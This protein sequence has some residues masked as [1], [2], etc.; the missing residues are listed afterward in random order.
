MVRITYIPGDGIGP[1]IIDSARR[2]IDASGADIVWVEAAAGE[3][4]MHTHG[5]PLPD[6]TLASISETRVALKGPCTTPVG[7]GFRSVNVALRQELDLYANLRP[8]KSYKGVR[9]RYHDVDLVVVREN[10]E[11]L[12]ASIEFQEGKPATKD[13]IAEIKKLD[14][15]EMPTDSGISIKSISIGG[16]RRIVEFAFEYARANGRKKVTA[17]HKANIMKFTDG[18]FLAVATE[19][20]GRYPD[21]AFE[22]RIVDNMC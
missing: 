1:S 14:G 4:A 9:S 13:L 17:V 19:V 22:D 7:K 5:S 16:S 12:Y 11:D 15:K 20:A 8:A 2:I 3:S 10:S 21:V 18:L 6:A